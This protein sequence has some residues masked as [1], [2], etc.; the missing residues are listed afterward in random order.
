MPLAR[1]T[2]KDALAHLVLDRPE[3]RNALSRELIEALRERIADAE[4]ADVRGLLVTA[5]GPTFC[6]GGD[7]AWMEQRKDDPQATRRAMEEHL[8]PLIEDVDTFP[9]PTVSAVRGAAIGAG[10][11]LAVSCD[12]TIAAQDAVLGATHARLGLTPDAGTSWHLTRALGPK[13]AL[14]LILGAKTFS[15]QEAYDW[16]LV[17][18][19]VPAGEVGDLARK[20]ARALAEGPTQALRTAR[21][22]VRDA[23]DAP[24]VEML[25]RE[26]AAQEA[27]YHTDDQTEGAE[28][29]LEDRE[30]DFIGR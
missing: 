7:V 23:A 14:D 2:V 21:Q 29:F 22:L 15:G 3:K 4:G 9:T 28:A 11:G 17:S 18:D 25:R 16:G 1:L 8:G 6:A 20:R 13:R 24:L 10:L 19:A 5:E 12:V 30:P 26:A 27:M